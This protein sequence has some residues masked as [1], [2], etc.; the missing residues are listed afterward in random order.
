MEN[1][2][3]AAKKELAKAVEEIRTLQ[4]VRVQGVVLYVPRI[5]V[6]FADLDTCGGLADDCKYFG[7]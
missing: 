1:D 3:A 6:Y 2:L 5:T 4:Q 7:Q